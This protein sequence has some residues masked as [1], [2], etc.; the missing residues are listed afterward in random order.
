[1]TSAEVPKQSEKWLSSSSSRFK[2]KNLKLSSIT[3]SLK[4]SLSSLSSSSSSPRNTTTPPLS[5]PVRDNI[6]STKERNG[7]RNSNKE[8]R[9]KEVFRYFDGDGDGKI[10]SL[11][12]RSYFESIGE[13]LSHDEVQSV[14][15]DLDSD[16]DGLLSFQ[17]FMVLMMKQPSPPPSNGG[18]ASA[19]STDAV[20]HDNV[21]DLKMAFEMYEAEKGCG[22]ITP[23]SLQRML[24]RLGEDKSYQQCVSMIQCFD[25]DKNGTLDFHEFHQMMV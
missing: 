16:G 23:K 18:G 11:E 3:G 19:S 6:L 5:S 12:L 10:S 14:I 25:L 21:E 24:N 13:S 20:V 1:M 15:N 17:D 9:F 2:T 7:S 4:R 22:C 8:D